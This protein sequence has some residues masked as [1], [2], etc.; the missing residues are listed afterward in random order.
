MT[1]ESGQYVLSSDIGCPVCG[2]TIMEPYPTQYENVGL[3][4][5]CDNGHA[6]GWD[7][8]EHELWVLGTG[9]YT[10]H[11]CWELISDTPGDLQWRQLQADTDSH[12]VLDDEDAHITIRQYEDEDGDGWTVELSPNPRSGDDTTRWHFSPEEY[13]QPAERAALY[14]ELLMGDFPNCQPE[15]AVEDGND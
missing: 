7:R 6:L 8:H 13:E 14:T 11:P 5:E 15:W 9:S 4:L 3:Q 12:I 10:G 1:D 2:T